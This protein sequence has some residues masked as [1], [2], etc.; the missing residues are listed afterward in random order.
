MVRAMQRIA[1]AALGLVVL[2]QSVYLVKLQRGL[3]AL[4]Q[5]VDRPAPTSEEDAEPAQARKSGSAV[6]SLAPRIP[7]LNPMP[8]TTAPPPPVLE[9]LNSLEGRQKIADVI[10]SLKEQRRQEKLVKSVDKRE[11]VDRRMRDIVAAELGLDAEEAAKVGD[12]LNRVVTTRRHAIEELQSGARSRAE[13]KAEIDAATKASDEALKNVLGEKR[14][15]AYRELRKRAASADP[16]AT[17]GA[18]PVAR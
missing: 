12:A 10:T 8:T 4:S 13:A 14:L 18:P 3:T 9:A 15:L 5:R 1:L 17:P 6:L 7:K 11:K 2:G 16:T